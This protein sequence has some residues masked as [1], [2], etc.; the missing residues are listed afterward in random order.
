MDWLILGGDLRSRYLALEAARAG[1]K[2]QTIGLGE[3]GESVISVDP[4]G[5]APADTVV[6]PFPI[7][8]QA[9]ALPAP[10]EHRSIPLQEVS[11]VIRGTV[12]GG[13]VSDALQAILVE[14]GA[15]YQDPNVLEP[16][17][18]ANAYPSAEGAIVSAFARSGGC[19]A[20][21][22][23]L[24]VGYG[25]IGRVLARLLVAWNAQV[26]VAAR[27]CDAR[28]W[29]HA[30]GCRAVGMDELA[31]AAAWADVV[32]QTAPVM[33]ADAALLRQMRP[34][35]LVSDLTRNGVDLAAAEGTGVIAWR[36]SGIPGRYAPET[37]G[38]ILYE[39]IV[40]S[41]EL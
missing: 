34:G 31:E 41:E 24:I 33:L 23:C 30:E 1:H 3:C 7:A 13:R 10:L 40:R 14:N 4:Q 35:T 6:L 17:S 37:A 27:K 36:D 5:A 28:A 11:H 2:V 20:G 29:A 21:S 32:F 39:T 12:W 15:S 38:K 26:C 25:R 8:A 16:F 9:D 18:I 19:V 22:R